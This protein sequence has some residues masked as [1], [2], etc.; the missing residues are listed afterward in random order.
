MNCKNCNREVTPN[1]ATNGFCSVDC[2]FQWKE[3]GIRHSLGMVP[4][5]SER[6][7]YVGIRNTLPRSGKRNRYRDRESIR[8]LADF[9]G[10]AGWSHALYCEGYYNC[11]Y[12]VCEPP[13][14]TSAR[15]TSWDLL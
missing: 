14:M 1:R 4:L 5:V 2:E 10:V 3:A 12:S 15:D 9:L 7:S 8:A 11:S 6:V 13:V